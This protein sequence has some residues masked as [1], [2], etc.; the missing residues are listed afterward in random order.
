MEPRHPAR[1][2]GSRHP[3]GPGNALA[4]RRAST[5]PS[6]TRPVNDQGWV[7]GWDGLRVDHFAEEEIMTRPQ[8]AEVAGHFRVTGRVEPAMLLAAASRFA[9]SVLEAGID[10]VVADA[11]VAFVPSLWP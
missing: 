1:Q 2:P 8:F 11:L 7:A 3:R 10:V 4:G 9:G 5:R 6:I